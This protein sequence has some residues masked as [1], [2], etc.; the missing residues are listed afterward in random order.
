M[1]ICNIE[2]VDAL[3]RRRGGKQQKT[4][5]AGE[6][7][8]NIGSLLYANEKNIEK[9]ANKNVILIDDVVTTGASV[10]RATQELRRYGFE[11]IYVL[12]LASTVKEKR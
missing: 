10:C 1:I 3:K 11:K 7:R 4:L 8:K 5:T 2:F 12:S 6:R 9:V